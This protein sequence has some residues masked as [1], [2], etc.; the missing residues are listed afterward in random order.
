M[1]TPAHT[2]L[3]QIIAAGRRILESEGLDRL[4]MQRVA[5]VVGVRAP[6]LYKR[7]GG[8]AELVRLVADDIVSELASR[9]DAVVTGDPGTDIRA[10]ARAFRSFA[11][12]QPEAYG[13]VFAR[14]PGGGSI[15]P[16]VNRRASEAVLR[17]AA[18]LAGRENALDAARTV[19][20]WAHGFVSME[21]AGAFRLG[22]DVD[23]A[24]EF[25]IDRL[26]SAIAVEA[27]QDGAPEGD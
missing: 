24:F 18:S 13:L 7:V 4:T 15:D 23:E 17:T 3:A 10:L 19:V 1:P 6:S 25:G 27:V 26:A 21:L 2:S 22:G 20:A 9:L 16:E 12:D 11:H 8:R 14:L 5:D